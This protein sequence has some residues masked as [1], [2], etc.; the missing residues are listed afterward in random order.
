MCEYHCAQLS[1]TTQHRT[2]LIIFLLMLQT[3]VI[4]QMMSTAGEE[5]LGPH[6][7][8]EEGRKYHLSGVENCTMIC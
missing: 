6:K 1:Y 5:V 8:L 3:V 7:L 2:V 4:A